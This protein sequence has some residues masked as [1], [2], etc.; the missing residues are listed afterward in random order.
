MAASGWGGVGMTL[1]PFPLNAVRDST[2]G[3][4]NQGKQPDNGLLTVV[5]GDLSLSTDSE[6]INCVGASGETG[7]YQD[8]AE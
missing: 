5:G 3:R 4:G 7:R 8:W 2:T 6:G 1:V